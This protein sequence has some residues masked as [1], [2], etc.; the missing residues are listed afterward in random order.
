MK[1][2]IISI[3]LLSL[4]ASVFAQYDTI[5]LKQG[6][7]LKILDNCADIDGDGICIAVDNCPS[8][9][10]SSQSNLDGDH[11]GDECDPDRDGDGVENS[12]DCDADDNMVAYANGAA[13]NDNDPCTEN[14]FVTSC[15]CSGT[16]MTDT[17]GDGTCDFQDTDDDDDGVA[18]VDDCNALDASINCVIGASCDDGDPNTINDEFI[19]GTVGSKSVVIVCLCEGKLDTDGDGV[20]DDLDTDDD[21]DGVT[22]QYD[23]FP[24]DPT[25]YPGVA[26]D[27]G[28]PNT[29]NEY[30]IGV[31][32]N[33]PGFE[34]FTTC[35]C[36][37]GQPDTDADGIA[38]SADNCDNTANA[39]QLD[40]DNDGLGDVCDTDDD[41]DGVLDVDDC[42][43][44]DPVVNYAI[45]DACDDGNAA[46]T[47]DVI[48]SSCICEG[49]AN[50]TYALLSTSQAAYVAQANGEW[51]EVTE[52]EYNN[53]Q[54]S[55]LT[56]TDYSFVASA[57]SSNYSGSTGQTIR[58]QDEQAP[59]GWLCAFKVA[60]DDGTASS[61]NT[62]FN[63]KKSSSPTSG[64][65]DIGGPISIS[66]SGMTIKYFVLKGNVNYSE[67]YTAIFHGLLGSGVGMYRGV[68]FGG[69]IYYR[70]GNVSNPNSSDTFYNIYFE[71]ISFINDPN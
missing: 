44:F 6:Q 37:G 51:I 23:C 31:Y 67:E 45:G 47:N 41:N 3:I 28:N 62:T 2:I 38:D 49:S 52:A 59:L 27:D 68:I 10:N 55:S 63:I 16:A 25:R 40:Y 64:F 30:L 58:N 60:F 15:N 9:A 8:T 70:S 65:T 32:N 14:D 12:V 50:E 11:L 21:N 29:V 57:P 18:D 13:C 69:S 56:Q 22:D 39:D 1:Q 24:I 42:D 54:N 66:G 43:S 4:T 48:N 17:D 33:F 35:S 26:C 7:V 71:R 61:F 46:T 19:C 53:I 20:T 36:E 5:Y 34:P